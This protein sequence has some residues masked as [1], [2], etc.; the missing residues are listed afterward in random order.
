MDCDGGGGGDLMKILGG[1]SEE[2]PDF[3]QWVNDI[4]D[5]AVKYASW[6][7]GRE[8]GQRRLGM[9]FRRRQKGGVKICFQMLNNMEIRKQSVCVL[10]V[11]LVN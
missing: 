11:L 5:G 6:S 1:S 7:Y 9:S 3:I 10:F 8:S 4:G 2:G